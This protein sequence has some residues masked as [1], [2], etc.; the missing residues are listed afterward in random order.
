MDR[1]VFSPRGFSRWPLLALVAVGLVAV[2]AGAMVLV[3]G[4]DAET[5]ES[6]VDEPPGFEAYGGGAVPDQ[7]DSFEQPDDDRLARADEAGDEEESDS[8]EE[9]DEPRLQDQMREAG[10]GGFDESDETARQKGRETA[11]VGQE[12]DGDRVIEDS[13]GESISERQARERL[14]QHAENLDEMD[15]DERRIR[16]RD[17]ELNSPVFERR[18]DGSAGPVPGVELDTEVRNRLQDHLDREGEEADEELLEEVG[19]EP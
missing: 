1:S 15:E 18:D 14:E 4:D 5:D 8:E 13:D 2:G 16:R 9:D 19:V 6:Q 3:D 10:M 12:P 11:V 17:L 7:D